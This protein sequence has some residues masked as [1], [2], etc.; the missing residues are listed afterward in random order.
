VFLPDRNRLFAV[1]DFNKSDTGP[2]DLA[3]WE[4][5][6]GQEPPIQITQPPA[7][8][9]GDQ[10]VTVN[11][12]NP[13]EIVFTR[14]A[15]VGTQL[16]EQLAWLDVSSDT[17]VALTS[18]DRPSRQAAYSPDA[19][20]IAYVQHGGTGEED[21]YVADLQVTGD[22]AE[23][24]NARQIV[25]GTIANPVWSPDGSALTYLAMTGNGFQ[26]WSVALQR[27]PTGS[28]VP[29]EPRQITNGPAVDAT[30]RPVL[31]TR[32]QAGEVRQWLTPA[33]T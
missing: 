29:G 8:S 7:Y 22:Q 11:P 21:L 30:S 33:A 12:D 32:E 10:D 31:L 17:L 27:D 24:D 14:Y 19:Q 25:T 2:G 15:Y 26:L 13:R 5:D 9:G 3:V 23:L 18:P 20:Q 6:F 4:L 1:G 28:M 16:A